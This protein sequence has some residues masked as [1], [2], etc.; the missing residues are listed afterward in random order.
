MKVQVPTIDDA[1]RR[2]LEAIRDFGSPVTSKKGNNRE[3]IGAYLEITNPRARLSQAE[4]RTTLFSCLGELLWYLARS[5][6]IAFVEYYAP[7]YAEFVEVVEGRV[8]GAYGPRLFAWDGLD[9]VKNVIC[10][11]RDRP[12]TKQAT[13]QLFDRH[14]LVSGHH[15]VPCTCTLQFL[16]RDSVLHLITTMRSNDAIRG[17][18]HDVFAFTM[19]QELVARSIDAEVGVYRHFVGSLHL[20]ERDSQ[21]ASDLLAEGWQQTVGAAMAPMPPGNPWPDIDIL[22]CA[23]RAFRVD[24]RADPWP[25]VGIAYWDGL[26]WLLEMFRHIK[27]RDLVGAEAAW[28]RRNTQYF[29][30]FITSRLDRLREGTAQ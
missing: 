13:I 23:E 22:L 18:P 2:S 4:S 12:T 3:V 28:I 26:I 25:A 11:L 9:Q 10:L 29:D 14:D 6:E 8:L 7:S 19:L 1:L 24:K 17:L 30:L 21:I 27:E 16:C 20:Y 15:D 5:S